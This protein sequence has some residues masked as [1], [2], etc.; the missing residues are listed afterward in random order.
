MPASPV[1]KMTCRWP[2]SALL[3]ERCSGIV[4]YRSHSLV[5][6]LWEGFDEHMFVVLVAKNF[7]NPQDV[8]L[9]ELW[10]DISFRPKRFQD[11]TLSDQP[12]VVLYQVAQHIKSLGS[13]RDTLL[14]APKALVRRVQP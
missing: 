1:T 5:S 13:E 9:D 4:E 6:P 11:F 14:S 12:P 2:R 10:V 8:F 3:S 7:A